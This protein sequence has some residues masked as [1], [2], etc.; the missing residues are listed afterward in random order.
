M[1]ESEEFGIDVNYFGNMN[2]TWPIEGVYVMY[3]YC[4]YE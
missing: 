1:E 2:L 3:Y 4:N